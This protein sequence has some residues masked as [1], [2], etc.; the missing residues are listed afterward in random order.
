MR[1]LPASAKQTYTRNI[2]DLLHTAVTVCNGAA[3]LEQV[4]QCDSE[5]QQQKTTLISTFKQHIGSKCDDQVSKLTDVHC[6][7]PTIHRFAGGSCH[8]LCLK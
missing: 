7:V 4:V 1:I 3:K 5:V 6:S 8:R 2:D